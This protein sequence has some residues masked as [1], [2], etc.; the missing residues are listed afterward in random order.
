MKREP[1]HPAAEDRLPRLADR[2]FGDGPTG[3]SLDSLRSIPL[4]AE[5]KDDEEEGPHR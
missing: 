5:E 3:P 4:D 1:V 2:V